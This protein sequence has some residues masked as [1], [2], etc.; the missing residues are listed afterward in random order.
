MDEEVFQSFE[1]SGFGVEQIAEYAKKWFK[2]ESLSESEYEQITKAFIEESSVVPDLRTNPLLLSLMCIIYRGQSFIPRNRPEVYERCATMLFDKWDSSR[3]IHVK[4]QAGHVVDPVLKH[5]AYWM[6]TSTNVKDG[7]TESELV[8]EV[9]SYLYGKAFEDEEVSR[10]AAVEFVDF[11]RGRAWVFSDAGSTASGELLFKFTHRTFMEYFA[12]Y[13]LTR[14]C[15]SPES[16]ARVLLPRVAKGEWDVVAQLAIQ[17]ENKN[18]DN[19]GDRALKTMLD[20]RRRR[21]RQGR[22]S[23]LGFVARCLSFLNARPSVVR[24]LTNDSLNLILASD[25]DEGSNAL[26]LLGTLLSETSEARNVI[27]DEVSSFVTSQAFGPTDLRAEVNLWT[28]VF[29]LPFSISFYGNN[30]PVTRREHLEYWTD[31]KLKIIRANEGRLLAACRHDLTLAA[32]CVEASLISLHDYMFETKFGDL[33]PLEKVLTSKQTKLF[34]VTYS[35]IAF[36]VFSHAIQGGDSPNKK[37][38]SRISKDLASALDSYDEWPVVRASCLES[39]YGPYLDFDD[40]TPQPSD[41]DEWFC[42]AVISCI[43]AEV[44]KLRKQDRFEGRISTRAEELGVIAK[45]ISA[46]QRPKDLGELEFPDGLSRKRAE[47]LRR[48]ARGETNFVSA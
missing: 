6:L 40:P 33:N 1:I 4:L 28:V 12:A 3:H 7:V 15:E 10:R 37:R 27:A 39:S 18:S 17:I 44:D 32:N 24:Q 2:Q 11:C 13:Q 8:K 23:V 26:Q 5:V 36:M 19:G 38:W 14:A 30:N 20:E 34:R 42:T 35:P 41:I 29:I 46:R 9:S 43:L 45:L 47:R 21:S 48:W 31:Q 22:A 16:L 25:K